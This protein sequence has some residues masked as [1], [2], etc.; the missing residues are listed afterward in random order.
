MKK[1]FFFAALSATVLC[2]CTQGDCAPEPCGPVPSERQLQWHETSFYAF[3]HFTTNT[4]T[5]LEW[6]RGDASPDIFCPDSLDC[7]QWCRVIRDAGMKGVVITAKHHDG[8]CLWPS[9]LTDYSVANSSWRD[10]K[11]DVVG[12]LAAAAAEYGLKFG[13]YLSPWDRH[14]LRYGTPAYIDYYRGQLRELLTRYGPVFEVWQDGAN[15]GDGWYGGLNEE[16]RVDKRVYYGWPQTDALI[17]EL[18]P[19][20]CIF[21]D[22]GP[23]CRWCGNEKG[24]VG[25]T[26]WCTIAGADFAPGIAD[27]DILNSGDPEGTDW[28]PA[29]VDVSVRPGWFWHE[30][31]NDR[32][33]SAEQLLDIWYSSVGRGANLILNL[34]PNN[35]GK[36]EETDVASLRGLGEALKSEF[37]SS[38]NGNV[39]KV[40]ASSSRRGRAYRPANVLDG[41]NRTFWIAEPDAEQASLTL[42]FDSPCA[43]DRV[44]IREYLPLGQRVSS[45]S[46]EI[47]SED[48]IWEEVAAGTTIGNMRAL[49]FEPRNAAAVRLGILSSKASPAISGFSVYK[50]G[51]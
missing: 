38:L 23:D 30:S 25:E 45:F 36:L 26:N 51:I 33:K 50:S 1:I 16:R 5:D 15:G 13:V 41:D 34:S 48:G 12:E 47:L 42:Q 19:D 10:G 20:A 8:F 35:H 2:G 3:V 24:F 21:S 32:V 4:F 27:T 49:R 22:G 17:H 6:G 40:E 31:E 7:R 37:S 44:T 29:E 28:I 39:K 18:Q 46:I 11:G 43:V 9:D 14:D